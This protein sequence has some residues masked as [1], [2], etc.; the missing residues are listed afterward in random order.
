[1]KFVI[2]LIAGL[3]SGIAPAIAAPSPVYAQ[4]GHPNAMQH[5]VKAPEI[6]FASLRDPFAS[7]LARVTQQSGATTFQTNR[8]L[9]NSRK[10]E[11]LE[12]YDLDALK[13]V[14]I[15]SKGGERVAM[16]EDMAS[17]G[18]IVRRGSRLG[19]NNGK[20]EKI[21]AD[22][23]FLVEQVL[24]PAGEIVDRQVTLTMKEVNE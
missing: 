24:N 21:D 4:S 18:Y 5:M 6:D 16:I 1:M 11:K 12:E 3:I 10:R 19:K 8:L 23:V 15:F 2:W 7:Y 17:K 22:T 14:A 20:I 9:L 13:L